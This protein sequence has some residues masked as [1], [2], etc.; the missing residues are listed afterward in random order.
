MP[1]VRCVGAFKKCT[2]VTPLRERV[3]EAFDA[4]YSWWARKEKGEASL[5]G[6]LKVR[7]SLDELCSQE[8]PLVPHVM[9]MGR[10]EAFHIMSYKLRATEVL[11][12][13]VVT[14]SEKEVLMD[15]NFIMPTQHAPAGGGEPVPLRCQ[16][17]DARYAD[18]RCSLCHVAF[19]CGNDCSHTAWN[20]G[21]RKECK[22]LRRVAKEAAMVAPAALDA[23]AAGAAAGAGAAGAGAAGAVCGNCG[24]CGGDTVH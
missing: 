10:D 13:I 9:H 16:H 2:G 5:V 18:K 12:G 19:Y 17:C 14:N 4:Q 21:H 22:A 7:C 24:N 20:G 11:M 3:L 23:G 8:V 15:T 1:C 6:I